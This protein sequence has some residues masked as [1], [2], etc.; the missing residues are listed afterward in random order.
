[1]MFTF[2]IQGLA[3]LSSKDLFVLW[4]MTKISCCE[5]VLTSLQDPAGIDSAVE[6]NACSFAHGSVVA[7]M[8]LSCYRYHLILKHLK[9]R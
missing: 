7:I 2:C 5:S 1:M 6:Q 9:R 3:V 8:A 4:N